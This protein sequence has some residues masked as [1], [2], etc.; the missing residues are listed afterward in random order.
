M[1]SR[2]TEQRFQSKEREFD[3]ITFA[4]I[5]I[6][7]TEYGFIMHQTRFA[8]NIKQLQLDCTFK[9]YRSKRQELA[10][11]VH[12][13]PDIAADVNVAAQVERHI[14]QGPSLGIRTGPYAMS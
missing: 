13:R 6:D 5:E 11:L 1:A 3:S 10:W 12:T 8:N 4:G 9:Q 2:L 14:H 7:R